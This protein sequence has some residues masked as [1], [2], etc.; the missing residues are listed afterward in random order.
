M[1][2]ILRV[3]SEV[4]KEGDYS[5]NYF[6]LVKINSIFGSTALN[7]KSHFKPFPCF[8]IFS[9]P[10]SS[11]LLCLLKDHLTDYKLKLQSSF[12]LSLALS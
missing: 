9:W 7:C 12:Y 5:C 11:L 3:R 2:I 8:S 10:L 4:R 1:N 6:S